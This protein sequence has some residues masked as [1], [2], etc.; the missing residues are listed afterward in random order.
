M[1]E[2]L[3]SLCSLLAGLLFGVGWLIW[4]DAVAFARTEYAQL[5]DGAHYIP[6]LLSTCSLV[7][8]NIVQ[9][10]SVSE[11]ES[12]LEEGSVRLS[13]SNAPAHPRPSQRRAKARPRPRRR[14]QGACAKCWVFVAFCL[15]FGGLI[16]AV[17]ILVQQARGVCLN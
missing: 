2:A 15:G 8:L 10:E 1:R 3:P 12:L 6:G 14:V 9:W 17:W 16:G 13:R 11:G 5:V 4:I 7:M